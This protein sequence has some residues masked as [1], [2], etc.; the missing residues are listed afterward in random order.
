MVRNQT[1]AQGVISAVP[2]ASVPGAAPVHPMR[3]SLR[4]PFRPALRAFVAAGLI[5]SGCAFG[6]P[7]ASGLALE[8]ALPDAPPSAS[9]F[10]LGEPGLLS[11]DGTPASDA[12]FRLDPSEEK[13]A[14]PS[15][16]G[17]AKW[18]ADAA[19]AGTAKKDRSA[20]VAGGFTLAFLG[21]EYL[22]FWQ[23][24]EL[25]EDFQWANEGWFDP[26]TYAGGA[27]KASH[28]VGGYIAGRFLESAL[29]WGGSTPG[30]A[31]L[32]SAAIIGVTGTLI[33]VGDAYHGFGFSWQDAVITASGGVI[34]SLLSHYKLDDTITMRWGRVGIDYPNDTS[35]VIGS[36]NHYSAEMYSADL[37]T[38]GLFRRLGKSP[39]VARFLLASVTYGTKGY[40]WV[41]EAYRQRRLGLEIGIDAYE[42]GLALG[43]PKDSWWGGPLLAF[44]RYFR[45]PYTGIGVQYEFNSRKWM[46]PNSFHSF[47]Q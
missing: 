35:V 16:S 13:A 24:A 21:L 30:K 19:E 20:L 29:K 14:A 37:R 11:P 15:G 5:L 31:E 1:L 34:G 36:P 26:D 3:F 9:R 2:G 28:L 33:E 42:V 40:P 17:A 46:G 23:S 45:I 7:I 39:G 27:D 12:A 38:S 43:V 22:A 44:L 6:E 25:S 18:S 41:E 4:L 10:R 32:M 8:A 47:D